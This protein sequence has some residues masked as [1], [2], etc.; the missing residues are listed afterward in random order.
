MAIDVG[1]IVL[2]PSGWYH[3][4]ICLLKWITKCQWHYCGKPYQYLFIS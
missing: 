3:L 1:H 4:F 2:L